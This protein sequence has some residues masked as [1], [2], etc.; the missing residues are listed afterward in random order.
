M[1]KAIKTTYISIAII[2][3]IPLDICLMAFKLL[4]LP[5][6]F[7]GSER[8]PESYIEFLIGFSFINLFLGSEH[9]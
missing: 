1:T 6:A 7:L 9:D 2:C 5:I 4:I 3:L 8:F